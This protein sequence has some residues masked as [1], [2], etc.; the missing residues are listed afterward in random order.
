MSRARLSDT[1]IAARMVE[2]RNLRRL[3]ARDRAQITALKADNKALRAE[4]TELRQL[5]A[6]AH[7]HIQNQ[8]I[9]IAELQTMVFGKRKRPSTGVP[10]P[11]LPT[12]PVPMRR[13]VSYRRPVPPAT[14]ITSQ[15][16]IPLPEHC[17]CGGTFEPASV[18]VHDRYEEDIP[19]PE[20]T[21]DYQPHLVTKFVIERGSCSR[22][23][24][25][26]AGRD[27]G[28]Q[29]VTL[30]LNVRLLVS[31]LVSMVGLSY[32]QVANVLLALY[33]LHVSDGEVAELLQRQYRR[34][35]PAYHRLGA[36][37]RAAPVQHYD[38]SPW[39]IQAEG[40]AGYV[41]V[42]SDDQT[43]DTLFY[44]A[45]SRGSRHAQKL[46]GNKP[47]GVHI[48]DDYGPY[49]NLPGQQQLCWVH[50]YRAIRD[51]RYNQQLPMTQ[52]DAVSWWYEQFAA[53]YEDLRL[54]LSEPYDEVVRHTQADEL[55]QRVEQLA[56][57]P[58]PL[59]GE[60]DKLRRLKAQLLR[61]GKD[62]L[63]ICLPKDTP[64]DNNRAERDL[65]QL[66]LKRQRSFGSK[67]LHGARTLMNIASVCTT[68]W[69]N[70]PSGY[71][72][73]LSLVG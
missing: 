51:V 26:Y 53:I 29:V 46:H 23:G 30:G 66:V 58:V 9:Q 7:A 19:L 17:A 39:A 70:N 68:T 38:E 20:L 13:A 44:A 47:T 34:W 57:Q 65:R 2:L 35:L 72:K 24:K 43:N 15:V 40:N 3:H 55:W 56:A 33:G 61:A 73:A 25:T 64:C 21:P 37:I 63:F 49:R 5:L 54:Y 4:V 71:F 42:T 14:A 31:H 59:Q 60:P 32:A 1:V 48:T 36:R 52:A 8:A 62:R 11:A 27:L 22:C 18:T 6:E 50:L 16:S 28:G 12:E 10:V 69:R 41:W 45:T 67:T